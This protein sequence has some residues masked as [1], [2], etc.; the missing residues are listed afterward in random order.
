MTWTQKVRSK[1]SS[2]KERKKAPTPGSIRDKPMLYTSTL[3]L[4]ESSRTHPENWTSDNTHSA[5][6][7]SLPLEIRLQIWREVLGGNLFHMAFDKTQNALHCYLCQDFST[8]FHSHGEDKYPRCQGSLRE[9]CFFYSRPICFFP[10]GENYAF[11]AMSFLLTCRQIY[12]E[13]KDMLCSTNVFNIDDSDTLLKLMALPFSQF[14]KIQT[15]H[16]NV[17]MWKIR[18]SDITQIATIHPLYTA[19]T[20]FWATLAKFSGLRHLR[21]DVYGTSRAGFQ[22][23]DLEPLLQLKGLKTFDLAV[24]RDTDGPNYTKQDIAVSVPLQDFIRSSVSATEH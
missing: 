8:G 15:M 21:L 14:Q 7:G 16:V 13:A 12:T 9:P 20:E 24:W 10:R 17:A 2:K 11:R 18:C 4:P 23:E 3:R 6:L 5:L 19:W 22:K 1:L